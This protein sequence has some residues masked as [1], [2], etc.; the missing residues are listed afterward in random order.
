MES[1]KFYLSK[2]FWVGMLTIVISILMLVGEF[3]STGN[4]RPEA[5]VTL[6][7]GSLTVVLRFLTNTSIS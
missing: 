4:F 6:V 2:T 7:S 5:F 3:L 1:K